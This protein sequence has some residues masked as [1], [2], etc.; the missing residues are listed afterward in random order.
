MY[1]LTQFLLSGLGGRDGLRVDLLFYL[2]CAEDELP[3]RVLFSALDSDVFAVNN[4]KLTT[5]LTC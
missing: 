3:F 5:A 1:L 4:R 2:T